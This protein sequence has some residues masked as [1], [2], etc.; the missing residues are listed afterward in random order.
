MAYVTVRSK[1]CSDQPSALEIVIHT[2][3]FLQYMTDISTTLRTKHEHN[4]GP[5]C[6]KSS[7]ATSE[8]HYSCQNPRAYCSAK[9][10]SNS[11]KRCRGLDWWASCLWHSESWHIC[12]CYLCASP[13]SHSAK[14]LSTEFLHR[15]S[16]RLAKDC[17]HCTFPCMLF[18]ACLPWDLQVE[19]WPSMLCFADTCFIYLETCKKSCMML[20]NRLKVCE[21]ASL[22]CLEL[23]SA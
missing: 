13:I 1:T 16:K 10:L 3:L 8:S 15:V 6:T 14:L 7:K 11:A 18:H 5:R 12:S 9:H 21:L 17:Y 2:Q 19:L 23:V 20:L 4:A 22:W